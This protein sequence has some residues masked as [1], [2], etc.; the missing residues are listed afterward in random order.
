[1]IKYYPKASKNPVTK[2]IV[3]V[4]TITGGEFVDLDYV[5][6]R[7]EKESTVSAADIRAVL[8]ALQ[9]VVIS[10]L[11]EGRSVRLGDLGSFRLTLSGEMA[12]T[13]EQC[14]EAKIKD[15]RVR[16]SQSAAMR[17][18]LV[19]ENLSFQRLKASF[20]T[21]L[22]KDGGSGS[23]GNGGGGGEISPEE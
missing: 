17:V 14:T 8:N 23:G 4:P 3:Y 9:S 6:K 10:E 11:Q 19:K 18:Q 16:F 15:V 12:P 5:S 13:A 20:S 7:I 21:L 2:A 22:E 1:M